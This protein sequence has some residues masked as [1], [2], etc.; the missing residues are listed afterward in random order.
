MRKIRFCGIP[1]RACTA[2]H[3]SASGEIFRRVLLPPTLLLS[4]V[5][6]ETVVAACASAQGWSAC[7]CSLSPV[8]IYH[9]EEATDLLPWMPR[10]YEI[11][12]PLDFLA[13]VTQHIPNTAQKLQK[14]WRRMA[15]K[16]FTQQKRSWQRRASDSLLWALFEQETGDGRENKKVG[17]D[18]PSFF[19]WQKYPETFIFSMNAVGEEEAKVG[20]RTEYFGVCKGKLNQRIFTREKRKCLSAPPL[21]IV[22]RSFSEVGK[23]AVF[24]TCNKLTYKI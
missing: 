9:T 17:C 10:N 3:F 21:A 18:M 1:L 23:A 2:Y 15:P 13:E 4:T 8:G 24:K 12:D 6:P 16:V 20:K 7:Q 14:K 5:R 11:Y 19:V 22:P